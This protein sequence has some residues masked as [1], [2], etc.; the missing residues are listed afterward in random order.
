MKKII[1]LLLFS[2]IAFP[3]FAGTTIHFSQGAYGETKIS[4]PWGDYVSIQQ[5]STIWVGTAE[6]FE[7]NRVK[8]IMAADGAREF[9]VEGGKPIFVDR[10]AS[11]FVGNT[12]VTGIGVY[13]LFGMPP[14]KK[15]HR[16]RKP[17]GTE[18]VSISWLQSTKTNIK[19]VILD[20]ETQKTY[21][22]YSCEALTDGTCY[23]DG[24]EHA[25]KNNFPEHVCETI[26]P[27]GAL[28]HK[29][30]IAFIGNKQK[31]GIVPVDSIALSQ[32]ASYMDGRK[33]MGAIGPSNEELEDQRSL[34]SVD[35]K[36]PLPE[37]APHP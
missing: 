3:A 37:T 21:L 15:L 11:A 10:G 28:N 17:K 13:I 26:M 22:P 7:H 5:G 6:E 19:E 25:C 1:F 27:R 8:G 23:G 18:Y 9:K 12:E 14:D 36:I 2:V 29:V 4:T 31:P 34:H 24:P 33:N 20:R 30:S 16:P 35:D 32:Y